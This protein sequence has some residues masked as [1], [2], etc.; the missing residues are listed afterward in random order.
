VSLVAVFLA[1]AGVYA[2]A[3]VPAI[4][5][6]IG[7]FY[8]IMAMTVKYLV[9]HRHQHCHSAPIVRLRHSVISLGQILPITDHSVITQ[10]RVFVTGW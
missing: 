8:R 2:V 1:V 7:Y 5:H 10:L 9:S 6:F 4:A 3:G